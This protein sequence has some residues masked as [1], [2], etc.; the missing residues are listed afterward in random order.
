[1]QRSVIFK[2]GLSFII[3][4]VV[5][6]IALFGYYRFTGRGGDAE[7]GA[8][9][10][11]EE[12]MK[13]YMSY[14]SKGDNFKA[15]RAI[16]A[17]SGK[18]SE[19]IALSRKA[20]ESA[21]KAGKKSEANEL[22]QKI[23]DSGVR[24]PK[25]LFTLVAT[26][27]LPKFEQRKRTLELIGQIDQENLRQKLY[28]LYY[29]QLEKYEK[30][31]EYFKWLANNDPHPAV[32]EYYARNYL[33]LRMPYRAVEVLEGAEKK[34]YLGAGG[35]IILANLF[36]VENKLNKENE[37]FERY[38]KKNG[39]S[40]YVIL[41]HAIILFANN[42]MEEAEEFLKKIIHPSRFAA[43]NVISPEDIIKKLNTDPALKPLFS[44]LSDKTKNVIKA[45]RNDIFEISLFSELIAQDFNR[46]ATESSNDS[47]EFLK[48]LSKIHKLFEAE[49]SQL[50][51]NKIAHQ[52]RLYLAP[53]LYRQKDKIGLENLLMFAS[54]KDR[55]YEGERNFIQYFI[56]KL[57]GSALAVNKLN[58]AEEVLGK[59]AIVLLTE[60]QEAAG[61][62][63]YNEAIMNYSLAAKQNKT[64]GS[65][66]YLLENLAK[67]LAD[68]EKYLASF[69]LI[70]RMHNKRMISKNTLIILRDVA[71]PAGFPEVSNGAQ[72]VLEKK[73]GTSDDIVLGRA[74]LSLKEGNAQAA[75]D[76]FENL[77]A[78]GVEPTY[79]ARINSVMAEAMLQLQM[80]K[81]VLDIV[82]EKKIDSTYKAR[83]L[84]GLGKHDEAL[85]IFSS[86]VDS[87]EDKGR[88]RVEY[89]LLLALKGREEEAAIQFQKA[90]DENPK[91]VR[92][93]VE[94]SSLLLKHNQYV[95]AK[96]Y[97]EEALKLV[98]SL[99][100]ARL[101]IANVD[102]VEGNNASAEI[103]LND[104][105]YDYP[106]NIDALFLKSRSL[107]NQG[108]MRKSLD[109]INKCLKLKPMLPLFLQHKIDILVGLNRLEEA[110]NVA[111]L[112]I[113]TGIDK[114]LFEHARIML[115]LEQGKINKAKD[116]LET[117]KNISQSDRLIMGSQILVADGKTEEAIEALKP[118]AT[119]AKIEFRIMELIIKSSNTS[120]SNKEYIRD[121][122]EKFKFPVKTLLVL[123]IMAEEA[124]KNIIAQD[125][126]KK[127]LELVPD[128]IHLLNNYIWVSLNLKSADK[129]EILKEAEKALKLYPENTMLLDTCTTAF[130]KYKEYD[131][132]IEVLRKNPALFKLDPSLYLRL[133]DAW[134]G[135][136]VDTEARN[137]YKNAERAQRSTEE[138]KEEARLKLSNL[139]E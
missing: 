129:D 134:L 105:L 98:S 77:L 86:A 50:G 84:Y 137:A 8:S 65:G 62:G 2:L 10:S 52:A 29:Y 96:V 45:D 38:V 24:D 33:A 44:K 12:L 130:N 85:E 126:Y 125:F 93:Y 97:A 20:A 124:K 102:I 47:E 88:W 115:L 59:N 19:N 91:L 109:V 21:I 7:Y 110:V 100:R 41:S 138:T 39:A 123:G 72:K 94:L 120:N 136:G 103:M 4:G 22:L 36:A 108:E 27:I 17:A 82:D 117:A 121:N 95:P 75:L 64:L 127:G 3:L 31:E 55:F 89:G 11:K 135:K 132:S 25:V 32:F 6:A 16:K 78:K 104:I 51:S 43:E 53:I 18:D 90:I 13:E 128:E 40:D 87:P 35:E 76:V 81:G 58:T 61:A 107:F 122:I 119:S 70:R 80:F 139:K 67:A 28:A 42:K 56:D 54:G 133:G 101:V 49:L 71:Y 1:M 116:A 118:Y 57:N 37:L 111:G 68:D 5:I 15:F 23:W 63:K 34:D 99:V 66:S 48:E 26:S 9:K 46:I 69:E 79:E 92:A 106:N 73:Y 74:E 30:A 83:A 14:S 114:A 113:E 112:G 60:A 131:K